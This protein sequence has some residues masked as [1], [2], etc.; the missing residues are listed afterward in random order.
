M[1]LPKNRAIQ[2]LFR[3]LQN[4]CISKG[5]EAPSLEVFSEWMKEGGKLRGLC[6]FTGLPSNRRLTDRNN[7][8]EPN[9][10]VTGVLSA[11]RID[12]SRGYE[13][14]NVQGVLQPIN[15]MRGSLTPS[16]FIKL[17]VYVSLHLKRTNT[18]IY[19]AILAKY[20]D[21]LKQPDPSDLKD[22][23]VE[24]FESRY[25]E[26]QNIE[27]VTTFYERETLSSYYRIY[28]NSRTGSFSIKRFTEKSSHGLSGFVADSPEEA[29]ARIMKNEKLTSEEFKSKFTKKAFNGV[30]DEDLKSLLNDDF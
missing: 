20:D 1:S 30:N 17:A 5:F 27:I 15:L 14:D 4:R 21:L 2:S 3:N 11:D 24:N 10:F 19:D 16:E 7:P 25:R 6:V 8:N 26:R 22:E 18:V 13:D 9:A 12:N 23:D 29:M 28:K